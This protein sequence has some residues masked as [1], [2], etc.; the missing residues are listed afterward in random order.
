MESNPLGLPPATPPALE[1]SESLE[2]QRK[3]GRIWVLTK[4]GA[5]VATLAC[6][7]LNR[8]LSATLFLSLSLCMGFYASFKLSHED[9]ERPLTLFWLELGEKLL[10][11]LIFLVL[12]LRLAWDPNEL[13]PTMLCAGLIALTLRNV[14][15]LIFS[16]A[17]LKENR[18]LP[19]KSIWGK[20]TTLALN[21]TMLLYVWNSEHYSRIMM[22]V[23]ELL[24][25][26]T[27]VGYLYF[28][29]RDEKS[30]QPV[31]LATQVTFSRIFLTPVF[32]WVFF[33][34]NNLSYQDNHLVFKILAALLAIFF[35]ASDGLDGYLARKRGEVTQLG[36]FLDPYSDKISNMGIFLCFLAS[37]YAA[38]WM[39][40][41]IF[42]R[43]STIETL[44]T[45]G[46]A[47]GVTIDARKSGKWKTA[48][49]GIAIIAI[50]VLEIV[51]TL[52]RRFNPEPT[53]WSDIWAYLPY[54]LMCVVTGVTLLSG[55][56]YFVA[57]KKVLKR[58]F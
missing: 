38:V 45:L 57:N 26:A 23:S 42:F 8:N 18:A 14:F 6:L 24:I 10:G 50:L 36:K 11:N 55:V 13:F 30:R 3:A 58:Y 37:G 41:V 31:S 1:T 49:Q 53:L 54:S 17:L 2:P 47:S 43:E 33:Y 51:D 22:V 15:Y 48:L 4:M 25:I 21:I 27:S 16:I 35:V 5:F 52:V 29:Y 7:F 40:A 20:I 12:F 34:D 19:L 28:Y 32:I 44:R 39:V 9:I 56:D 46:A